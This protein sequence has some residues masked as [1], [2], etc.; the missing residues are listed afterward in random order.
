MIG[1]DCV[2]YTLVIPTLHRTPTRSDVPYCYEEYKYIRDG[3]ESTH[4]KGSTM[5]TVVWSRKIL[6]Y[7]TWWSCPTSVLTTLE[8]IGPSTVHRR[9]SCLSVIST[10]DSH[11]IVSID[12]ETSFLSTLGS[13]MR[14]KYTTV[15]RIHTW[16][17]DIIDETVCCWAVALLTPH[18]SPFFSC[19]VLLCL[20]GYPSV[21]WVCC[22]VIVYPLPSRH[23]CRGRMWS[24]LGTKEMVW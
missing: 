6:S 22:I 11:V 8:S 18:S 24:S 19:T 23:F 9:R 3:G 16:Y 1:I 4:L 14:N 17:V 10:I 2:V 21:W 13:S 15:P 5:E 12:R 7:R 20:V